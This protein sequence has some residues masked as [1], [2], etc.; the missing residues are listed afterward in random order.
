MNDLQLFWHSAFTV[1]FMSSMNSK[2]MLHVMYYGEN[3][4]FQL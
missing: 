3:C 4:N 2:L 1:L